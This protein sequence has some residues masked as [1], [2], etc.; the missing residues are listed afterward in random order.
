MKTYRI[1]IDNEGTFMDNLVSIDIQLPECPRK[2]DV[3]YLTD[4]L[5]EELENKVKNDINLAEAY[6]PQWFFYGSKEKESL[7]L[8]DLENLSFDDAIIV[9]NIIFKANDDKIYIE[10][11]DFVE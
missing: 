4:E 2:G 10:L 5:I 9:N 7:N 8:S 6:F 11:T 1:Y 3:L